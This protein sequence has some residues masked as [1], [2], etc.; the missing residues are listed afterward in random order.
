MRRRHYSLKTFVQRVL[1]LQILAATLTLALGFGTLAFLRN[2]DSIGAEVL[3]EARLRLG[4]ISLRVTQLRQGA[5]LDAKTAA[6]YEH[7]IDEI[8][9]TAPGIQ[10]GEFTQVKFYDSS[11][12]TLLERALPDPAHND[13]LPALPETPPQQRPQAGGHVIEQLRIEGH[14]Y[15]HIMLPITNDAGAVAAYAEGLFRLSDKTVAQVRRNALNSMLYVALIVAVTSLMLYPLILRLTGRLARY[16]ERLLEANLE[17]LE[18]LG[19]AIAKRDSD[20]DAHN[21][22]VTLY[23]LRLAEASGL[24]EA[25]MRGLIKGAFLHDAG[26]IGIRDGIL[27]K[28]ARLDPEEFRVMQ[29]HVDH[30]MDIVSRSAWLAQARDVVGC[31]HEK[32]DGSGYPQGLSGEDIPLEARIFAI[33][34]VFDALTSRRPYKAPLSY[35]ETMRIL[36][37]GRG[38]HFD[39]ALFDRFAGIAAQLHA[40]YAG[41]DDVQLR[42]E[43]RGSVRRFFVGGLDTLEA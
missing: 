1:P 16:S 29:T 31:H 6:Q 18:V 17:T 33:V 28:P 11:G 39:P 34:D 41:R 40:Q 9:T 38:H 37:A 14:P 32:Y 2:H 24:A 21:Y 22:R 30:G 35:E 5:G 12:N 42:E 15:L 19:S 7:A 3:Q 4:F 26:K 20:T 23:A 43:L 36:E 10:T 25:R 13:R 27:H 8:R